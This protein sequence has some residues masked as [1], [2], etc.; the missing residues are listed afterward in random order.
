MTETKAP[1]KTPS[2]ALGD[3]NTS[4]TVGNSSNHTSLFLSGTLDM[5][6]R[7]AVVVLVPI[8]VGAKLDDALGYTPALTI[9]GLLFAVG[10]TVLVI[11]STIKKA[12][13][14]I[15]EAD[16]KVKHG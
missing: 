14:A 15:A 7:L 9:L 13:K 1:R 5:S 3:R 8:A 12:D 4:Q 16:G 6:W 2:P 10:S 11:Q